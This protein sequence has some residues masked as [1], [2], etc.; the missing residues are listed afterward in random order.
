MLQKLNSK[1]KKKSPAVSIEQL[2]SSINHINKSYKQI[3][4]CP[5]TTGYNWMGV[6]RATKA[7]FPKNSLELPQYYS[8]TVYSDKELRQLCTAIHSASI[9]QVILSGFPPYFETISKILAQNNV[10]VK[11]I[12]HGFFSELAGNDKQQLMLE[13]LIALTK[14]GVISLIA[15]NKKGMAESI[16]SLWGIKT[17]KIILP[18]PLLKTSKWT[19]TD[20]VVRIGIL[21][22]DQF[23]KNLHN[24]IVAAAMIKNAELHITTDCPLPY[25][26]DNI[27][28]I[29]H[30]SGL[31][32]QEFLNILGNMDVNLHVS[33]SESWGQL[34]TESLAL[35]VPCLTAYHSDVFDYNEELKELLVINDYDNSLAIAKQLEHLIPVSTEIISACERYI[36]QL[37]TESEK[38]VD[39]FLNA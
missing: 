38:S 7:L 24:Q 26:P 14:D 9:E 12:Y 16:F 29:R 39:Y 31:P 27:K 19:K 20:N 2:I 11:V 13:K 8:E 32:H 21:G 28:I 18:T 15:F 22:N 1:F 4:I 23:R 25:L 3:A 17:C 37:N 5:G 30:P 6:N 35:G 36:T 10:K 34:T 33:Y